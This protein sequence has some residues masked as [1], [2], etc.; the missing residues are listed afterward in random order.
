MCYASGTTERP[1]CARENCLDALCDQVVVANGVCS[2]LMIDVARHLNG[3]ATKIAAENYADVAANLREVMED[4]GAAL[5][6]RGERWASRMG[7][8]RRA[9]RTSPRSS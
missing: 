4:A 3:E 7:A 8:A 5:N 6:A 9:A 2:F 1:G